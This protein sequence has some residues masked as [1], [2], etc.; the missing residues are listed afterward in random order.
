MVST[1]VCFVTG[2]R[3]LTTQGEKPVEQLSVGNLVI[4]P[5]GSV[6]KIT[7]L[8]SYE[9]NLKASPDREELSPIKIERSALKDGVPH[10]DLFLSRDHALFIDGVLIPVRLLVNDI[11]IVRADN[12]DFVAYWHV[13]LEQH[14]IVLAEGAAAE[15]YLEWNNRSS[16][17]R[18]VGRPKE[19]RSPLAAPFALGGDVV[20][21]VHRRLQLRAEASAFGKAQTPM[22]PKS[23]EGLLSE[24]V[25]PLQ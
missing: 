20:D 1:V 21:A 17:T 6:S 13:E 14:G 9:I 15:S 24:S 7:W 23:S 11:S 25:K 10:R 18:A 4:S 3:I 5:A 22:L 12:F 8:G 19:G 16:F 2:T